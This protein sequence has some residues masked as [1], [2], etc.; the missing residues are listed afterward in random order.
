MQKFSLIFVQHLA[1]GKLYK[2]N[3]VIV[4]IIQ[5][6]IVIHERFTYQVLL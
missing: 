6:P 2:L 3:P 4:K 1:V 5:P